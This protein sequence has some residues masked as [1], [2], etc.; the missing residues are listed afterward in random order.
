MDGFGM[1]LATAW[2]LLCLGQFAYE[3]CVL[4]IGKA[5]DWKSALERSFCMGLALLLAWGLE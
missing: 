5:P 3:M 2:I 4:L 1:R